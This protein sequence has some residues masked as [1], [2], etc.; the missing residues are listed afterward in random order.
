MGE[1]DK[2]LA[3][4]DAQFDLS[5]YRWDDN[6]FSD[7]LVKKAPIDSNQAMNISRFVR[8]EIAKMEAYSVSLSV[9]ERMIEAKLSDSDPVPALVRFSEKYGIPATQVVHHLKREKRVKNV[10]VR[11]GFGFLNS[12]FI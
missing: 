11:S 7:I 12:L 6:L 5:D 3:V 8:K 4:E 10:E 2:V 1:Q 9:I